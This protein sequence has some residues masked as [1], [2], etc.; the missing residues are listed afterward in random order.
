MIRLGGGAAAAVALLLGV[1]ACSGSDH[2]IDLGSP[3]SVTRL[4]E[5]RGGDAGPDAPPT[6]AGETFH[7]AQAL[8]AE[9]VV[10]EAP[11]DNADVVATLASS[12]RLG[13]TIAC[14]VV[15]EL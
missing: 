13:G 2:D 11:Q 6:R 1:V 4:P 15:Q 8:D 14:L 7:V 10:R 3:A 5:A 9:L 12:D